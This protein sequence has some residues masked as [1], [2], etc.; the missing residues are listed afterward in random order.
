MNLTHFKKK[1]FNDPVYGFITIPDASTLKLIEHP[2]FQRLRRIRQLGMTDLVYPGA[3]HSRFH[4][5]LGAMHL[6]GLAIENLRGKGQEISEQE[7]F[8]ARAAIL[9]HDIGHGPFSHALEKSILPGLK[10]EELSLRMMHELNR[11]LAFELDLCLKIFTGN[12]QKQFLHQLVSSQLDVD[13]L[14]YLNRDSFYT[15]VTEGT[16]G[17]DRII[18]M[19]DVIDG[20]L[21]IEEKGIYSVE[22]FIL[23][24]RFMYWQV[25]LHKTVISAENMLVN[26]L[27]RARVLT[28]QGQ[29]VPAS[30]NLK[31][32]LRK[33]LDW[34]P[35]AGD[36]ETL[37]AYAGLDD[38]DIFA[39][40]K[41]WLNHSDKILSE[42]SH[43]LINRQLLRIRIENMPFTD[44]MVNRYKERWQA[45]G[46]K[47]EDAEYFIFTGEIQNS[48]YRVDEEKINV[49]LKSGKVLDIRE[50]SEQLRLSV[51]TES[52]KKYFLCYPKE[53]GETN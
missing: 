45:K 28:A 52:T 23:A 6:M 27:K 37:E 34:T 1:I 12:Y 36:M 41:E 50:A 4:H 3:H 46:N 30:R 10:H 2:W 7:A 44:E 53:L 11:E 32:F 43:R 24:R 39:S 38:Y 21:V 26:L 47:K 8:G 35:E 49:C 40:A 14:D 19:M 16:V 42:L 29:Q 33:G 13:R 22:K 9:L 25:Y 5:A 17:F 51:L 15:G 31:Y 48:A 18:K 20:Q